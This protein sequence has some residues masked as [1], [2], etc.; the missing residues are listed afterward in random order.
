ME[1]KLD[2]YF[3]LAA[4]AALLVIGQALIDRV[5]FL[6]SY[7]IPAAVV[8]GVLGAIAVTAVNGF[9]LAK[10]SFDQSLLSPLNILF[11]TTVGL[12]ADARQLKQGGKPLL[13]FL[14]LVVGALVMQNVVGVAAALA[15]DLPPVHG[16]IAGSITLSGGHGTGAAWA[17]KF[18][19]ERA[20]S[21]VTELALA[22][23]TFGLL[24][25]GFAGGPLGGWLIRRHGLK[26]A[27]DADHPT[28]SPET[29][30][31]RLTQRSF[32]V[33]LLLAFGAMA[34]GLALYE[35]LGKGPITLPSF[36]WA[37]LVGVVIRNVLSFSR[38]YQ[39]DDRTVELL[40]G[41]ALSLFL[42]MVI[43]T[44]KLA[45]LL[46]LAG[47]IAAILAIQTVCMVLYAVYL[48]F[49]VMGRNYD[50]ALLATGQMGFAMGS[51]ATAVANMQSVAARFGYSPLAFL[52]V[53]ITGAFLIDLAN[54][55]VIQS[56]LLLPWFNW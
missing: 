49:P 23:A 4:A 1:L 37:L 33:T 25:G 29:L 8:G 21:G 10:L 36:I 54:A 9:G 24:I 18:A 50:A 38:L 26:P 11:F 44:L 43:M 41:L 34:V 51:T 52:L 5:R 40:G 12:T 16:L 14:A 17:A 56:F 55:L 46:D 22:S 32:V 31:A 39:V 48:T 45:E 13:L 27:V 15:F 35:W 19:E 30:P 42:A 7:S 6:S 28:E 20:I 53:P 3:T 2:V 47:P